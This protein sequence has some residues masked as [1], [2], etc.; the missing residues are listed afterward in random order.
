MTETLAGTL[1]DP[2]ALV[3]AAAVEALAGADAGT[4]AE[5]LT[6]AAQRPACGWCA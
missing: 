6:A 2:D 5:R 3:R 4:R 1:A